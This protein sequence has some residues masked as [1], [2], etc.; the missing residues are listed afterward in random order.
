MICVFGSINVIAFVGASLNSERR[1]HSTGWFFVRQGCRMILANPGH[2]GKSLV[3]AVGRLVDAVLD[4]LP[5][6]RRV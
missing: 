6:L 1:V 4:H 2:A 3:N 5:N